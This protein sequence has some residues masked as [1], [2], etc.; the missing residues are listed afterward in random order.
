MD[1]QSYVQHKHVAA[2]KAGYR[3][4]RFVNVLM[5]AKIRLIHMKT[6]EMSVKRS[7]QML[8]RVQE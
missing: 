4:P 6:M 7:Y 2:E 5:T 3:A 1:V 8:I